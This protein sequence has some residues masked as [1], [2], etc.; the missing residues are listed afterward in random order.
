MRKVIK[1]GKIINFDMEIDKGYI[2]I[3]NEKIVDVAD[4]Y[5]FKGDEEIIDAS[6]Y[7]VYPG[8]IDPHTHLNDPGE[9]HSEDFYS[10]TASAAAGGITTVLDMPVT[11]PLV[12]NKESLLDKIRIAESKAVV[13]VGL[14]CAATSD[15]MD[16]LEELAELGAI[17]FK[18]YLSYSRFCKNLNLGQLWEVMGRIKNIGGLI[19]I[20]AEIQ[21]IVDVC[22]KPYR[23]MN[24][25]KFSNFARGRSSLAEKM[26]V[27]NAVELAKDT[28]V[29]MHIVHATV[30]EVI[31]KV[32]EAKMEGYPVSVET[33]PHYLI[34]TLDD[35]DREEIG[36]FGVCIPP[37]REKKDVIGLWQKISE[38][39]I[40]FVGSDH[41][42][43]TFSEK[44]TKDIWNTYFGTTSIQTMV[45]LIYDGMMKRNMSK[46]EFAALVSS[47]AARRYGL[48]NKG[49]IGKGFDADLFFIDPHSRWTVRNR[50]LLY[51]MKWSIYEGMELEGRIISTIVRGKTVYHEGKILSEPGYGK[52]VRPEK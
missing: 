15:N 2:V 1:A 19:G 43:Y 31:E 33:C 35:L 51:K 12:D 9:T 49:Y 25:N 50:E 48:K 14:W 18:A 42:T 40:D 44:D 3:E 32:W 13:D 34:K 8:A 16:N 10:G 52:F 27:I 7:D 4:K 41:A 30:P 37:L 46:K 23:E 5:H 11:I 28:G 17:G 22:E 47:N 21:D 6:E 45:P 29:R 24:S 20:H 39:K 38:N 36:A 26:A